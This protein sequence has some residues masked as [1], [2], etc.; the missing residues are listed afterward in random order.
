MAVLTAGIRNMGSIRKKWFNTCSY[1]PD[2]V[3]GARHLLNA[4]GVIQGRI[5]NA[6]GGVA[7][8][9]V[10]LILEY[11]MRV[12][13]RTTTDAEGYFKFTGLYIGVPIITYS[14]IEYTNPLNARIYARVQAVTVT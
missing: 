5:V 12:I 10:V 13:K 11:D 2:A 7:Y 8:T 1:V 6:Q 4:S 14:V 3:Q 9:P